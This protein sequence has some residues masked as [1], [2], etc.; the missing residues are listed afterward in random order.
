ARREPPAGGVNMLT[1][2]LL[3]LESH[4]EGFCKILPKM[5]G[6]S[7]LKGLAVTHHGF[8]RISMI[9]AGKL[10]A[11]RLPSFD[12]RQRHEVLGKGLIDTEH[13]QSFF[14]GLVVGRVSSMPFLPQEFG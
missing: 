4:V 13:L 10:F 1:G 5:V 7:R 3:I 11:L 6:R 2:S 14:F 12:D 8:Y 9:G